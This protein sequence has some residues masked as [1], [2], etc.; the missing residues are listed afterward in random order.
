MVANYISLVIMTN[1]SSAPRT[2][3][4]VWTNDLGVH[5][6]GPMHGGWGFISFVLIVQCDN[7]NATRKGLYSA[8]TLKNCPFQFLTRFFFKKKIDL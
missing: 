4:L 6:A 7:T 8:F 2:S 3:P 1:G 5:T